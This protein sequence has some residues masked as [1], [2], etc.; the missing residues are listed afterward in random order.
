MIS[1]GFEMIQ[2]PMVRQIYFEERPSA[3]LALVIA[4]CLFSGPWGTYTQI[5]FLTTYLTIPLAFGVV[6][7][8]VRF[9]VARYSIGLEEHDLIFLFIMLLAGLSAFWSLYPDEWAIQFFWLIANYSLYILAK[10]VSKNDK[11]LFFIALTGLL[12]IFMSLFY[13]DEVYNK[14]GVQLERSA[15]ADHNNNFTAYAICSAICVAAV[16]LSLFK[17]KLW[18]KVFFAVCV[19]VGLYTIDMLGTRGAQISI[20][21]MIIALLVP[22]RLG[23]LAFLGLLAVF[24]LLS[25]LIVTGLA[26]PIIAAFDSVSAR[27]DGE[28]AGRIPTWRSAS[29]YVQQ[30]LFLGIGLGA[31]QHVSIMEINPHNFLFSLLLDWGLVGTL[32]FIAWL[33]AGFGKIRLPVLAKYRVVSVVLAYAVPISLSGEWIFLPQTWIVL[34]VMFGVAATGPL[35]AAITLPAQRSAH[36]PLKPDL[37]RRQTVPRKITPKAL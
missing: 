34:G 14:W 10:N 7:I 12:C 27:S 2:G 32:L 6:F 35:S 33:V 17:S 5:A 4:W 26:E 13:I 37:V 31:F 1:R 9:L 8:L 15:I 20:V 24:V 19:F 18:F 28:L 21:A 25:V 29:H 16:Y 36:L 11:F 30:N 22:A 3:F 23:K